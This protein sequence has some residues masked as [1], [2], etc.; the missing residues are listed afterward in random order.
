MYE[1]CGR[2]VDLMDRA[3]KMDHVIRSRIE[4]SIKAKQTLMAES[5]TVIRKTAQEMIRAF[6]GGRAAYWFGNGGSAADAQ[7]LSCELVNRFYLDRRG[8][9]SAAFTT[10]TS[11]LTS[12]SN[13]DSFDAV[14]RKQVEAFAAEGDVLVGLS[15]SGTS[16]NVV[17]ALALGRELG[18]VNV[19]MTGRSGGSMARWVDHLITVPSDDTPCV[20]ESHIMIGHILCYLV[21][22]ELFGED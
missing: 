3:E 12:V 19:G 18:T 5:L 14:F 2:C 6:R 4:D 20:Q 22:R 10:D 7:H 17:D 13:D 15:T 9:R 8:L 21:E 16:R 11:V 1:T